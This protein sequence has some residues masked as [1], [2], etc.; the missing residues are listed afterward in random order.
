M[1]EP[2][3]R[4]GT[5]DR[6]AHEGKRPRKRALTLRSTRMCQGGSRP[7]LRGNSNRRVLRVRS[8]V[9]QHGPVRCD[10]PPSPTWIHSTWIQFLLYRTA[11][12]SVGTPRPMNDTVWMGRFVVINIPAPVI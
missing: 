12:L 5:T 2:D 7:S 10:A 9:T 3:A 8:R 11:G 6:D 1:R 4:A